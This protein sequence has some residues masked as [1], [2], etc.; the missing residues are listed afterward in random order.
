MGINLQF[1]QL[2]V[3]FIQL[4]LSQIHQETVIA[5]IYHYLFNDEHTK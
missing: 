3:C 1:V 2:Y 5:V 4:F